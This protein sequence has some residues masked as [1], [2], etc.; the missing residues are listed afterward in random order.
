VTSTI[1]LRAPGTRTDDVWEVSTFSETLVRPSSASTELEVGRL[2]D[3]LGHAV[4]ART[5]CEKIFGLE[6]PQTAEVQAL[7]GRVLLT[8]GLYSK[9]EPALRQAL[10]HLE[11]QPGPKTVRRTTRDALAELYER[12]GRPDEGVRYRR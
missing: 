10:E 3:A 11:K 12:Q 8:K 7:H 1:T 5:I 2:D 9:A 4:A 6:H